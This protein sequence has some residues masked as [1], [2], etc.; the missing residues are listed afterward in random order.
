MSESI[1]S[2]TRPSVQELSTNPVLQEAF[3]PQNTV[4]L[5]TP[6]M[7]ADHVMQKATGGTFTPET[8][9]LD[10]EVSIAA[11]HTGVAHNIVYFVW[12]QTVTPGDTLRT[13]R[14]LLTGAFVPGT[15]SKL[16]GPLTGPGNTGITGRRFRMS[17]LTPG[18][19]VTWEVFVGAT[20]YYEKID[21]AAG[22]FPVDLCLSNDHRTLYV[23]MFS[24]NKVA[25]YDPG[26]RWMTDGLMVAKTDF[27]GHTGSYG[28][29]MHPTDSTRMYIA[30]LSLNNVVEVDTRTGTVLRTF[31]VT[32]PLFLCV[33]AD[34]TKLFVVR[35]DNN[36]VV[37]ITL[38]TAV[39]GT[40]IAVGTQPWRLVARDTYVYVPCSTSNRVDRIHTG[41]HA[42]TSLSTGAGTSPTWLSLDPTGN[43]LWVLQKT[44]KNVRAIDTTTFTFTADPLVTPLTASS[45]NAALVSPSGK[46]MVVLGSGTGNDLETFALPAKGVV[47][48]SGTTG[49]M[50]VGVL[51]RE[52]DIFGINVIDAGSLQHWHAARMEIDPT[53]AFWGSFLDVTFT[54]PL[55]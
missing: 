46:S 19:P 51:S 1:I 41:T 43:R 35:Q 55:A 48:E 39:V 20:G 9:Q 36:T 31:A 17:G 18:V 10:V 54:G 15:S 23:S 8:S 2:P 45:P 6:L 22:S 28:L 11:L 37:P 38:A 50:G 14:G 42:V 33:S 53:N 49:D 32:S 25:R 3:L 5:A 44:P 40:G 30:R 21:F 34:A 29:A 27:T 24:G 12:N 7:L 47:Y 13:G 4:E 26:N 52:G 16:L